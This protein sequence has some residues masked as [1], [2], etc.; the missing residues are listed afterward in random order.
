MKDK[1]NIGLSKLS[2]YWGTGSLVVG[3]LGIIFLLVTFVEY[4]KNPYHF[5][6]LL[7]ALFVLITF[8]GIGFGIKGLTHHNKIFSVL[9]IMVNIFDILGWAYVYFLWLTFAIL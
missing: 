7:S 8:I 4:D 5:H 2:R 3:V 6:P 9:G 1:S